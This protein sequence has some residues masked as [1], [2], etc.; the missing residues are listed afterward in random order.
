[1]RALAFSVHVLTAC[2]AALAL[3][4]LLA[5]SHGDWPLMFLWLGVALVVDAIDGPLA[6]GVEGRRGLPRWSGETLDLVVDY[7]T[8]VFVPAYA[9][10]AGG[11]MPDALAIPPAAAIAI[12]GTLYFADREMK[13]ADNFFRGFPAVWNL[14]VFY[15]LLLRPHAGHRGGDGRA[16]R[17]PDIRAD[18]FRPSVPGAAAAR[19]D[20]GAAR[21]CGPCWRSR[22]SS[23]ACARALDF[24]GI[25]PDCRLFRAWSGC[26]RRAAILNRPPCS[27]C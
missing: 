11:L 20:R 10:A 4:A 21:R 8:Y 15:L 12:T 27:N 13:T 16:V 6:R 9:V 2:G 3:L 24:R 18:P 17:R 19:R 23:G 25:M 7:T 5:A 22:P 1:M 14:V 26:C